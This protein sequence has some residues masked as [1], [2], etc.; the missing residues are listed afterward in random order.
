[1]SKL[2]IILTLAPRP[3]FFYNKTNFKNPAGFPC[4]L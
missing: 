1:M 2:F 4:S 3:L